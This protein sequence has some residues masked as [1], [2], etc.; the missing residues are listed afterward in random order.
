MYLR[1]RTIIKD[2]ACRSVPGVPPV[3]L[4]SPE[5]SEIA[6][7]SLLQP[8]HIIMNPNFHLY[9]NKLSWT[10]LLRVKDIIF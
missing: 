10:E 3:C 8:A 2:P 1:Q 4:S 7:S 6:F 9:P 5:R